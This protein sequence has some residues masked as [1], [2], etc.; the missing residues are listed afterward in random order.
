MN[1]GDDIPSSRFPIIDIQRIVTEFTL[2]SG[3]TA[4]I[5]GLSKTEEYDYDNGIPYLCDI[6]WIGNKLFDRRGQLPFC[7][8]PSLLRL[9]FAYRNFFNIGALYSALFFNLP[10][11]SQDLSTATCRTVSVYVSPTGFSS[12]YQPV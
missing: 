10:S 1:D 8:E 4:V 6:P 7:L 9:P 2:K 3:Q 5:G 11:E 12:V